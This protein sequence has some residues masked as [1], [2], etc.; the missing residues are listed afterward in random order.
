MAHPDLLTYAQVVNA[1]YDNT[2]QPTYQDA[3]GLTHVY[4]VDVNG[5]PHFNFQGTL[6][7]A[8]WINRDLEAIGLQSFDHLQFGVLHDGF[9][10]GAYGVVSQITDYLIKNNITNYTVGGHSKGAGE[11]QVA[12]AE[13]V[14]R[15]RPPKVLYLFEPPRAGTEKLRGYISSVEKYA[16]QTYNTHGNDLVTEVPTEPWVHV[17][18]PIRLRVPDSYDVATKHKV[19]A[20]IEALKSGFDVVSGS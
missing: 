4:L 2:S 14:Y 15:N 9:T 7:A 17:V 18:T 12:T 6:D 5:V 3:S 1:C 19:P 10:R 13:L 16:T 11:A 8:E 20:V